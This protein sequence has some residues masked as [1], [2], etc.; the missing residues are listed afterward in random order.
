[1]IQV[2]IDDGSERCQA[3]YCAA[4]GTMSEVQ[5]VCCSVATPLK[6]SLCEF[7]NPCQVDS[8][9][10]MG[11][12]VA[13]RREGFQ[14]SKQVVS[15]RNFPTDAKS[16]RKRQKIVLF[17]LFIYLFFWRSHNPQGQET[18]GAICVFSEY[19]AMRIAAHGSPS[20]HLLSPITSQWSPG[21][22]TFSFP[23]TSPPQVSLSLPP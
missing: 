2:N 20:G 15:C 18:G 12:I 23:A 9:G 19:N 3:N 22:N 16:M 4:R 13:L 1:M 17:I 7:Q 8:W 6:A 10:R 14:K 5:D 21:S 11:A